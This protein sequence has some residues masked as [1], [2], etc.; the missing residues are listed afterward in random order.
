MTAKTELLIAGMCGC[1]FW[2]LAALMGKSVSRGIGREVTRDIMD[3]Q[4]H[5]DV[6][7]ED[8]DNV[9]SDNLGGHS[10]PR[11]RFEAGDIH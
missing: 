1:R 10:V 7:S 5:L 6:R 3:D 2:P 4:S 9:I 11:S 8:E